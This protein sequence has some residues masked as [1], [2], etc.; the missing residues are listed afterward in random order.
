[1]NDFSMYNW[2]MVA[3]KHG[4]LPPNSNFIL[5]Y[6]STFMNAHGDSCFPSIVKIS[7]DTGLSK[8]TVIKHLNVLR[9][10]GWLTSKSIG[11]GKGW[12]H[13][14]YFPLI[15]DKVVKQI[16]REAEGGKTVDT[17]RLNES[18][19]AVKQLNPIYPLS[20]HITKRLSQSD[21]KPVCHASHKMWIKPDWMTK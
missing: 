11:N 7:K 5:L 2:R 4:D 21:S 14:Q 10:E 16:N 19:K 13:N 1:M 17:R 3:L 20:N 15:P 18:S 6:L 8:P 9:S 12:A